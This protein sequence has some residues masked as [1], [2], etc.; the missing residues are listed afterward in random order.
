[1]IF[2]LSENVFLN[3]LWQ[4]ILLHQKTLRAMLK[5]VFKS[6]IGISYCNYTESWA[7]FCDEYWFFEMK[8]TILD[9]KLSMFKKGSKKYVVGYP[10]L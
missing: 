9:A 5:L 6:S 2:P 8:L 4:S 3:L 7:V 1:M 10:F